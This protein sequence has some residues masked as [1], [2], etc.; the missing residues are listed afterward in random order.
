MAL[1][2][3]LSVSAKT[4]LIV[5]LLMELARAPMDTMAH[6]VKISA[7][8][9]RMENCVSSSAPVSTVD[10]ART[11]M[12][13]VIVQLDGKEKFVQKDAPTLH[14]ENTV[15]KLVNVKTEQR[16]IRPMEAAH[17]Q[18]ATKEQRVNLRAPR[19]RMDHAA[20]RLVIASMHARVIT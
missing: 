13:R 15:K 11:S 5:I 12:V 7:L 3:S 19:A 9:E 16:A 10:D 1:T 17:V 2:A 18:M 14:M 6:C 4:M 20:Q 8:R